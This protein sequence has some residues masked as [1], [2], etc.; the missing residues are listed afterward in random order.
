MNNKDIQKY[1]DDILSYPMRSARQKK[2]M[3]YED[4]DKHLI[5]LY[6]EERILHLQKRNL[7]WEGLAQPYQRGWTR[8]FELR[9][10]VVR[11]GGAIFFA[12]ILRKINTKY[13]CYRKD[14]MIKKRK[15]GKKI[16]TVK[17]QNLLEPDPCHFAKLKF[18]DKEK[19]FFHMR[20]YF[21]SGTIEKKYVFNEPWR[22][23]VCTRPNIITRVR[24]TDPEIERQLE[25][26]NSFLRKNNYRNRQIRLTRGNLKKYWKSYEANTDEKN[27]LKNKSFSR[28]LDEIKEQV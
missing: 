26:I 12:S 1:G 14:F 8:S 13:W 6:R 18:T 23:V 16:Y 22:F 20:E 7:G 17:Q 2:R 10:D 19:Q 11:S 4:L 27:W 5:Q 3:V 21:K 25:E 28:I 9:D 15:L 24:K